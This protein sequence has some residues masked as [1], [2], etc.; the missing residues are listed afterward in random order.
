MALHSPTNDKPP[1]SVLICT[2]N[3]PDDI[4]LVMPRIMGQ[5]YPDYE[6]VIIDQSADNTSEDRVKA[7]YGD[8]QRLRYIRPGTS[9][10]SI[11]RNQAVAEARY[12]ICACTDDDVEVPINWLTKIAATFA[13]HPNTD[14]LYCPVHIPSDGIGKTDE[15]YACLYFDRDRL[16]NKGEIFGMGANMAMRKSFFYKVGVFDALLGA[17]A[18]LPGSD[19]HDWLYRAH[20]AGG[21]IRLDAKNPIDHRAAR[22]FDQWL[23]VNYLVAY[24][25]AAYAMKHLRCGD[26]G[27]LVKIGHRLLYMS[28]RT[29]LRYLQRDKNRRFDYVYT[30]RYWLGIWGSLKYPVDRKRRLFVHRDQNPYS[31]LTVDT[32]IN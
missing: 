3:R 27:M 22:T 15:Y 4:V 13:A 16:L 10:L 32:R 1:I 6:V 11:A 28:A 12:E 20:L 9:G 30:W 19:E 5:D 7:V 18:P 17:G 25:D 21:V 23:R 29:C 2:R 31:T 26:L 14:V 8:D 24:G